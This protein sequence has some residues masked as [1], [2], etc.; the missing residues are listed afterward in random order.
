MEWLDYCKSYIPTICANYKRR[1]G[2]SL[3]IVHPRT[4]TEK[5]QWLKIYDSSFLKT[6]CT[7]KVTIHDYCTYKLGYDMCIP[8]LS[9]YASVD[10]IDFSIFSS[11]VVFKCNHGSGYNIIYKDAASIN[12][13][14]VQSKL[15][16]WMGEDFSMR[17]G[18]ELHYKLIPRQILVEPYMNDGH[19]DLIDY[20][21]YCINGSPLFCQVISDRNTHETI[22]HYDINW[23]YSP[24]YDWV[25]FDSLPN[26]PRPLFYE[27]M[28]RIATQLASDF[29]LV[30]VDFYV[31]SGRLYLGELT[32]TPNSGYHHF[33]QPSMDLK[34]GE[35]L[36][37]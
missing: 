23:R 10:D 22:S 7:D 11:G 30:R 25:E 13:K 20:K 26:I 15:T 9:T 5:M 24:E 36:K 6:Y 34:L 21:F 8:I 19:L 4:F 1:M 12:I 33:R 32:F 3:N 14:E 28:L 17:N 27:D 16:R 37:L 29:R 2:K 18:C 35:L 31:I